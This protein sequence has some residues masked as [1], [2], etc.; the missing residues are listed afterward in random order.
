MS[1]HILK[2]TIAHIRPAIWRRLCVP[3][4]TTLAQLHAA[5]QLAFGWEDSHLH[6]F[7]VGDV[8]YGLHGPHEDDELLD[9]AEPTLA[10]VLPRKGASMQYTYDFGDCWIHNVSVQDIEPAARP[11]GSRSLAPRR[12]PHAITC[13]DGARAAPPRTAA[14]RP[15]T[16]TSS[17]PLL[18]R[19][20]PST[21][22]CWNRLVARSTRSASR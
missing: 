17:E 12:R 11:G 9:E 10:D 13:L 2:V 4:D 5:L 20:I 18:T 14:D 6:D 1:W 21:P 19:R 8:R 22:R 16:L 7:R 15:D 3:S